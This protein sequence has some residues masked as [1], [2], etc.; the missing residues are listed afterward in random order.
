M[1]P[2]AEVLF[3]RRGHLGLITL[4]R[5]KALNALTLAM[6]RAIHPLLEAWARDPGVTAVAIQGAG[7]KAFCAGG[8]IRALYDSGKAGTSLAI[9]FYR[10]EY[11]LNT[12]IKRF[13]KPFVAL[14][15]G[16]VMGGGVGLSVHGTYR[17]A[18]ERILF[19][20]PET[21]IGLFPDVG[22][23][24]FLPR[25]PGKLG[26]CLGLTGVRLKLEDALWAGIAT[27]Y[28]PQERHAALLYALAEAE[29]PEHVHG[30]I[31]EHHVDP[32]KAPMAAHRDLIDRAFAHDTVEAVIEALAKETGDFAQGLL[33]AMKK[34]SPTS[35]KVTNRQLREGARLS[36]EECM[37]LE[38]RLTNRFMRGQDFYEGVRAQIIDKDQA[39]RWAPASLDAVSG[40]NVES[41]FADLGAGELTLP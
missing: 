23:T 22:G 20:M 36:F 5:P 28:V 2:E 38:F 7:E 15:N 24:Y 18:G 35:L 41:Y 37:K 11:K 40:A 30:W 34:A 19:A 31:A 14:I 27:H 3:E 9:D 32:D 21:G 17:V 6:V 4:N 12:A 26:L 10:E 13:P 33:S 1:T 16:I 29:K 39:P 8:D 25:L